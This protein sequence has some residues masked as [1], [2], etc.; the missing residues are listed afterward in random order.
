MRQLRGRAATRMAFHG[1]APQREQVLE[2]A[3]KG[4][5]GL[6]KPSSEMSITLNSWRLTFGTCA[7][8]KER[9]YHHESKVQSKCQHG[10]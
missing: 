10:P 3:A 5:E 1:E 8:S 4:Q 9:I 6:T 7:D 2:K